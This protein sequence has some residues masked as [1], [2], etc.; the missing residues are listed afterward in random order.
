MSA[1]VRGLQ[2]RGKA[3][4]ARAQSV[5]HYLVEGHD[6]GLQRCIRRGAVA[7]HQRGAHRA[8]RA[9]DLLPRA[10]AAQPL[11]Q[12]AAALWCGVPGRPVAHFLRP[13]RQA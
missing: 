6:R 2:C 10:L 13:Q 11:P 3:E 8:V 1:E 5:T 9:H 4:G 7:L 12:P